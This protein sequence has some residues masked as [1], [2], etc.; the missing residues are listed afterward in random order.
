VV[1]GGQTLDIENRLSEDGLFESR[2][3]VWDASLFPQAASLTN[4]VR[5]VPD[6]AILKQV[7][8]GFTTRQYPHPYY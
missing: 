5:K 7:S 1:A 6:V 2:W 3:V 4:S 8:A